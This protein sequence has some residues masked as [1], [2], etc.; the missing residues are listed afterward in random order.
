ML[1]SAFQHLFHASN[2]KFPQT[3]FL[4]GYRLYAVDGFNIHI[5]TILYDHGTYYCANDNSE[6]YNLMHLNAF[7]D[8][9]NKRYINTVLQ[10]S[11]DEN[12]NKAL[13]ISM[14]ENVHCN[15]IIIADRNY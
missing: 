9:L 7:Y 14:L 1:L 5:S 4:H 13:I 11:H 6:S 10:D 2:K 3:N 15:S 12:E 8:L